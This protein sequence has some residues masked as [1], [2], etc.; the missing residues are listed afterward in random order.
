MPTRRTFVQSVAAMTFS[1]LPSSRVAGQRATA[2]SDR[3]R[4][5]VLDVNET[6]LDI[7]VLA[8]HFQRVFGGADVLREWFSILLLYSNVANVTAQYTEFGRIAGAALDMVA[9]ARG[10]QLSGQDRDAVLGLMRSLPA[11]A[12]VRPGLERLRKAGFRLVTLTNS[13]P[14][15][16]AEQ[17]KNAE[18]SDLIER[19]FSVDAV[20]RFKPAPEPYQYVAR[21]LGVT[22]ANLRLV[23]AHAWDVLGALH[24]GCAAAFLAR[25]GKVLYPLGPQPDIAEPD[26]PAIAE[27]VI[28]TDSGRG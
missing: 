25:P 6:L 7:A 24:A 10:T 18:L 22:T 5:I 19:S 12:D 8:P 11:H 20:K 21:E 27:R 28:A 17:I 15:V 16:V 2:T 13:A 26:L 14:A 3:H 4:I 1:G 23:A 9:S